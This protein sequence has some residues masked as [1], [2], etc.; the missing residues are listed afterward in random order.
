V[1]ATLG[2]V[3]AAL[4]AC[5]SAIACRPWPKPATPPPCLTSRITPGAHLLGLAASRHAVCAGQPA[6]H[7]ESPRWLFKRGKKEQA[8]AALL[9]SRTDE[10]AA[11]EL[12]EMERRRAR[13]TR[14]LHRQE[15][16][17]DSLLRRKY[18]I[19]FLLACVILFCNTATG[20]NSI[21]GY[22]TGILLQSGLSD[23]MRTGA[24]SSSPSMN[25][26]MT[27]VGMALVDRKGRRFL[28]ILGTSGIIVSLVG[29]GI[30]FLR[31][32]TVSLD[33][34]LPCRPWYSQ[35]RN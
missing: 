18:V 10:Q 3:F 7:G 25:F 32:E 15:K 26:L 22:N 31:T 19:P 23:L 35:A 34:A 12:R 29:V 24:M 9:R 1:A 17:R 28:L 2:M 27:M 11:L 4:W 6:G 33:A 13:Q 20:I 5:T 30:L 14:S 21:I 8:H 16:V